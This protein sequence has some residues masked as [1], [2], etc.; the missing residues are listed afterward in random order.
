MPMLGAV[1][2]TD[3][4]GATVA[5]GDGNYEYD[6]TIQVADV[7]DQGLQEGAYYT[8]TCGDGTGWQGLMFTGLDGNIANFD[9]SNAQAF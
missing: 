4:N 2:V 3:G 7:Q 9:N 6:P 5:T 8:L 1:T